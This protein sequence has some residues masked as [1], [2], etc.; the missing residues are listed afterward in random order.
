[1]AEV[2]RKNILDCALCAN[3]C[4]CE[5]PVTQVFSR[6]AVS[7]AGKARLT[8]LLMEGKLE[9]SEEN[10]EAISICVGCRGHRLLC[11][12]PELDLSR[13][14]QAAK[15]EAF[16]QGVMLSAVDVYRNNLKNYSSPYGA[17]EKVEPVIKGDGE[18]LFFAGCTSLAN[19]PA[20][21]DATISLLEKAGVSY[22]KLEEDCCGY[23]AA[24]WGDIEL[25]Q[26]LAEENK[27]RMENSGA[28][29]LIT[30]C[31]ECWE[32][33]SHR[34]AE[35]GIE[36]P[37]TVEDSTTYLLELVNAGKLKPEEVEGLDNVTYH[38]PCIWARVEEKVEEPREL[39]NKIPGLGLQ[40][41]NPAG[42]KSRCCGGGQMFQLSFPQKS[43]AIAE[44]RL[45]EFPD[46]K[47]IV[48]P[49]PF[50]REGLKGENREVLEMVELLDR[51]CK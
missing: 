49:C 32:V 4:R 38:D 43:E 11:P 25:A 14:L 22:Q 48:T 27:K 2:N 46:A 28:K 17:R 35:W 7:P 3:M 23:P 15:E 20:S 50:C 29:R 41:A 9:W 30:N 1:M 34:Y 51:A 40:E 42:T 39:L 37:F 10:L 13:E 5:C 16:R 45:Q 8:Y 26:Q 12:F 47:A 24:V 6:E 33:F 21:I 36:L 19:N 31:P 44:R 18:V